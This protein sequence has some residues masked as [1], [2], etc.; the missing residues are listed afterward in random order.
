[1]T[2]LTCTFKVFHMNLEQL[3]M[4]VQH[5]TQL[6][7]QE[8]RLVDPAQSSSSQGYLDILKT[9][10]PNEYL[11]IQEKRKKNISHHNFNFELNQNQLLIKLSA[12]SRL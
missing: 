11:Q 6:S 12:L 4:L 2:S 8:T 10:K 7:C 3:S 5:L 9:R 1:M